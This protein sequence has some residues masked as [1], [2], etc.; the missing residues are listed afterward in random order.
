MAVKVINREYRNQFK[1]AGDT[2][3][4]LL[5]NAGDWQE[6]SVT[7]EVD[8]IFEATDQETV[9]L[10]FPDKV[11]TLN[12]GQKWSDYGFDIGDSVVF[13]FTRITRDLSGGSGD[14]TTNFSGNFTIQNLFGSVMET[15][16]NLGGAQFLNGLG[17]LP[18]D[19]G[20]ISIQNVSFASA[21][22]P[23]G[24]KL[25]YSLISNDDFDTTNLRSFFDNS[26]TEFSFPGLDVLAI[27]AEAE[28]DPDG[29]QSG[30]A[31]KRA[32][33][34]KVS[35]S[36]FVYTYTVRIVFMMNSLFEEPDNL[37]DP[38]TAPE[39]LF[40]A[41]SLTDNFELVIYPEWNNPNTVI[42]NDLKQTARLGNTGWF[43]ENFNGLDNEFQVES[44]T[45]RDTLG[46]AI[47]ALDYASPT[48][49][50]ILVS[51]IPNLTSASKF[52][53]GFAWIPQDEPDYTSNERPY[54]N[55]LLIN[56]GREY[57]DGVADSFLLDEVNTGETYLG[58]DRD[59]AQIDAEPV[60]GETSIVQGVG[61]NSAL[62]K[63]RFT[64]NAAFTAF[65][66]ARV[67]TDRN[68]ILWVSV[69]DRLLRINF[70]DRVSLLADSQA[71]VKVVQPVG[72]FPGMECRFIEHPQGEMVPGVEKY[73][74][75]LNDD[76]LQRVL[77]QVDTTTGDFITGMNFQYIVRNSET[78]L[79]QILQNVPVALNTFAFDEN[80]IQQ[81][82]FQAERGFKL[83]AGNNKNYVQVLRDPSFDDGTV[84]GFVALFAAKIRWE[85]WIFRDGVAAEYFNPA[86]EQNGENNNWLDY[87]RALPL[88]SRTF[89]FRVLTTV[90]Q[91]DGETVTYENDFELD[92]N[93]YDENLNITTT[94]NYFRDSDNSLLNQGT[95]PETGKPLGVIL[96]APELT[97]IEIEFE[98]LTEDFDFSKMYGVM[99]LEIDR[100]PG[101]FEMRQLSS[102]WLFEPDNPLRPLPGETNLKFELLAP[103]EIRISALVDPS[104][105]EPAARYRITGRIGCWA[106]A[107]GTPV[108]AGIYETRYSDL[109]E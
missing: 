82:N 89:F 24:M 66:D 49:V 73:F 102:V 45:Y 5:G 104:L 63:I 94:H 28:M 99:T 46:N 3:D 65:F 109:Y 70:S 88:G 54:Q 27:G 79:E 75:F 50:E 91:E 14:V 47:S 43:N 90:L 36:D 30:M 2:T 31:I 26:Q 55:N 76:I 85:D 64:P 6:L 19:R 106:E 51:G 16:A 48:D 60:P 93:G 9:A 77:F 53:W 103:R 32:T 12:N 69:A 92:F 101:Q 87:L 39:V 42:Q 37:E 1:G 96:A 8:I 62:F 95:D 100:G 38:L 29:F 80:G 52:G 20:T 84:A 108:P 22:E 17:N 68:Y 97:R 72:P 18:T 4:W 56:T 10:N 98:N 13:R 78:E 105:L 81:L 7:F 86:L 21:K 11:F 107:P 83:V 67:E 33:I 41:G 57:T 71:L 23:E 35:E 44:I 61:T 40:N 15:D 58:N 25:R 74:G 34:E 59:G